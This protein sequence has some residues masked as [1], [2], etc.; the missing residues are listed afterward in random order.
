M[1]RTFSAVSTVAHSSP[2]GGSHLRTSAPQP[3]RLRRE[4]ESLRDLSDNYLDT[5]RVDT[6][7]LLLTAVVY[8]A[9]IQD[10][11]GG[12]LVLASLFDRYR[13]LGELFVDAGYQGPKFRKGLR[14]IRH[15]LKVEIV[16]RSDTGFK[17]LPIE[18]AEGRGADQG[19]RQPGQGGIRRQFS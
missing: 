17:V 11:D 5:H 9:N 7:G 13:M 19:D 1:H 2:V 15:R 8:P 18:V 6:I 3:Q 10:R 16:K 4:E 14:R 12:L